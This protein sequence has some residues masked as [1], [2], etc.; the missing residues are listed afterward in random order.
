MEIG[1]V[2]VSGTRRALVEACVAVT[3]EVAGPPAADPDGREDSGP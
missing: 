3:G 2:S 1:I